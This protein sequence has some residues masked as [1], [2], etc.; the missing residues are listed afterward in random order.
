MK[1][2]IMFLVVVLT[3]Q[4]MFSQKNDEVAEIK[5]LSRPHS[6]NKIM[7]R[8]APNTP[9]SYRKLNKYGYNVRRYTI[10]ISG[11]TL[12]QPIEKDLGI[13][14]PALPEEWMKIIET[15]NNAAVMAQSIF[16]DDFDVEGVGTLQGIINMSQEQ[17]QRFTWGLYVADQDFEVAKLGGLGYVD[18]EVKSTEKYVYKV[19]SL[20]PDTE[21]KIKDGGVFVGLQDFEQLPKPLDL[22]AIFDDGKVMLNWNYAIHSKEYNSYFIE[23]SED[24]VSF[25]RL[26]KLPYTTLNSGGRVDT[27]RIYY[28]DSI[29]N[30]KAYYYRVLGRTPFGEISP[31]SE[32]ISGKGLKVL[33]Y[34]PK[35]TSKKIINDNKSVILKWEFMKEGVDLIKGFELNRSTKA[36]GIYK[37]IVKNIPQNTRKIQYDGLDPTNYFTIT[38]VGKN[39][40][41][42]VSYPVLVQP[43]DSIPPIK[44]VGLEGKVD[45]LGIVTLKWTPNAEPDML[46]YR[47]FRGNNKEEEYSQITI[48]PHRATTYYDS[49]SVKSLNDKVFYKIVAVDQRFNMSEYSDILTLKK[50]DFIPPAPPSITSYNVKEEKVYLTWANSQSSDVMQH[51]VFRRVR[52]SLKWNLVATLPKDSLKIEYTDWQDTNIE[53]GIDYQY[54]VKAVDDDNLSSINTQPI[55]VEVPRFTLLTGVKNLNTYVDKNNAYIELFW[56]VVREEDIVEIMIYKG[57]KDKKMSLLRNVPPVI[58][59]IVDEDV[60]PNNIYTYILRPV[61][62]DGSLGQIKKVEVKY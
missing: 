22:A 39:G 27:K 37:T 54:L 17:E 19:F 16:G 23:R 24:G 21:M 31:P 11:Q 29:T 50:P 52:D 49:V 48:N 38:A 15:N 10:S 13:F 14:K 45:S 26:N 47:I 51:E 20:V 60:K 30:N 53:G 4:C 2:F 46:G 34:V 5:V 41:N 44:P 40:S 28:T 36:N 25:S 57:V 12:T 43:V 18:Y 35:I 62:V 7:L 33:E 32:I 9:M 55:T 56:K 59:R 8:W 3:T 61:F 58:K 42:R 6:S 1:R